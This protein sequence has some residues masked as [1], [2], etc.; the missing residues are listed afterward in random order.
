MMSN[1]SIVIFHR[2]SSYFVDFTARDIRTLKYMYL[3]ENLIN[4]AKR[5]RK[6]D[7]YNVECD[8]MH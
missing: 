7:S 6:T 1:K 5:N 4:G 3:I 8:S 2:L